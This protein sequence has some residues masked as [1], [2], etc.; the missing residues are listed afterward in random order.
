MD[1]SVKLYSV[2]T[3]SPPPPSHCP[4]LPTLP[5]LFC[6]KESHNCEVKLSDSWVLLVHTV[7]LAKWYLRSANNL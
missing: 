4:A 1:A 2:N 7:E 3:T 6:V 5:N